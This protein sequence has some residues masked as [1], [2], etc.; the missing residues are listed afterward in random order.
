MRVHR[1]ELPLEVVVARIERDELDLTPGPPT[2][3]WSQRHQ[4]RLLDTLM[5]G[6]DLPSV[7]IAGDEAHGTEFVVDGHERLA[8]IVRFLHD[9][10]PFSG[11]LSPPR[12]ELQRLDNLRFSQFPESAKR[13]VR[14]FALTVV[15]LT[16]YE[17]DEPGELIARLDGRAGNDQWVPGSIESRVPEP[18]RPTLASLRPHS[19]A[20]AS[21]SQPALYSGE[22]SS[23][24]Q[25]PA[26][27]HRAPLGDEPIYDQVSAWF[28]DLPE[29]RDPLGASSSREAARW[30]SP[31][32]AG[33]AAAFAS[34]EATANAD[35]DLSEAGLP[36]RHPGEHLIPGAID[37]FH[38]SPEDA[39]EPKRSPEAVAE[40]LSRYHDGIS[41]AHR[42]RLDSAHDPSHRSGIHDSP[43]HAGTSTDAPPMGP[44]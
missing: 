30:V 37:Q 34:A 29:S 25:K 10:L 5:R 39:H 14:R 36:R 42:D 15:A 28:L 12:P 21:Q 4:Q 17:P 3:R 33:Q 26:G 44:D 16:G 13:Q 20:A 27:T 8:A 6:W 22:V 31:A 2:A 35:E 32:D 40:Q 24:P 1:V 38:T 41:D 18:R 23:P 9:E 11:R 43:E 7:Y 19:H